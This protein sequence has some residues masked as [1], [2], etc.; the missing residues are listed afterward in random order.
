MPP[1]PVA[2]ALSAFE[3]A[4][5][6]LEALV[7]ELRIAHQNAEHAA[8]ERLIDMRGREVLRL[9]FQGWLDV[10]VAAV[11]SRDVVGVDG[12]QRTHPR[13]VA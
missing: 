8:V 10:R 12:V 1:Y 5:H 7:S 3:A 2:A 11:P 9:V 4:T 6:A 13:A